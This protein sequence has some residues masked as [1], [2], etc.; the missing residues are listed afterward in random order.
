MISRSREVVPRDVYTVTFRVVGPPVSGLQ[1]HY[2][3]LA[4]IGRHYV[5]SSGE[6]PDK[7]RQYTICNCMQTDSYNEYL[8]VI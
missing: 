3:D 4:M 1:R 6:K 8:R 5:V 2:E 7:K